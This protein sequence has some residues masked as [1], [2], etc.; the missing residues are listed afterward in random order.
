LDAPRFL[1]TLSVKFRHFSI[2]TRLVAGFTLVLLINAGAMIYAVS[3]I[4]TMSGQFTGL[5]SQSLKQVRTVEDWSSLTQQNAPRSL[6]VAMSDDPRLVA[7]YTGQIAA[8]SKRISEFQKEVEAQLATPKAR[9]LF[10]KVADLRKAYLAERDKVFAFK[11]E[12]AADKA[13]AL[14]MG[15]MSERLDAYRNAT[16]ELRD[17]ER[18]R[19]DAA[20]QEMAASGKA[21]RN[22]LLGILGAGLVLGLGIALTLTRGITGPLKSLM[23]VAERVARGDL[24]GR[25]ETARR[26]EIGALAQSVAAMQ[27]NLK[28]LIGRVRSDVDAVTQSSGE[29]AHAADELSASA[30]TQTEAVTSTASSVQE[31]TASIAQVSESAQMARA[32]AEQ[33]SEVS[34][35]GLTQGG[36]AAREIGAIEQSIGEFSTQMG[37]LTVHAG[38]IGSVIKLI[39]EIADQTNLL[40]LNAA[41]EA[42]R[43]GEQGRGFAVVADEVRKLA[44]RTTGATNEIQATIGAIQASVAGAGGRI[45]GLK[46]RAAAG[47]E[48]IDRLMAPLQELRGSASRAVDSLTELAEATSEQRAASEQIAGTTERVAASAE[49]NRASVAQSRDTAGELKDLAANLRES[50]SQFQL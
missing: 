35:L 24:R 33:T 11:K 4:E 28:T 17:Y 7:L 22:L 23:G 2:S 18:G 45:E 3:T 8:T 21:I 12:G 19:I 16:A 41:I 50:V 31:L 39:K 38:E 20:A 48:C 37:E 25:I 15:T 30:E 43:A 34:D 5:T 27:D 36:A 46:A 6:T 14:A 32:V 44:E 1:E 40:A 10:G 42:A 26:D 9:E 49:E 13:A 29:L 47:V